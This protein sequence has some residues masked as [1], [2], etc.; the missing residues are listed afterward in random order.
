MLSCS[1]ISLFSVT[2]LQKLLIKAVEK[3]KLLQNVRAD[4]QKVIAVKA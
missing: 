2:C 1:N 4:M 3:W